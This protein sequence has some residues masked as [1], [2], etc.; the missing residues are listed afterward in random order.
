MV[1]AIITSFTR[2]FDRIKLRYLLEEVVILVP[3]CKRLLGDN[4]I[5]IAVQLRSK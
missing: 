4:S 5:V 2:E 3:D 1:R